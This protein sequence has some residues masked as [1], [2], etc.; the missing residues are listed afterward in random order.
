M[1]IPECFLK[2]VLMLVLIN[3]L[4]G[5]YLVD[6]ELVGLGWAAATRLPARWEA[7]LP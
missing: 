5:F 1:V 2:E 3:T 7:D 6:R 4:D